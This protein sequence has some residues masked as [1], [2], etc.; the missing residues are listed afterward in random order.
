MSH[1]KSNAKLVALNK[2][3]HKSIC[4]DMQKVEAEGAD[5]HMIP[6]VLSEF[7][8]L[9]VQYPIVFSKN[10]QTGKFMCSALTGF[11]QGENL[12]WQQGSWQGVYLPLQIARQPFFLGQNEKRKQNDSPQKEQNMIMCI[13]EASPA[14][15]TGTTKTETIETLFDLDGNATPYLQKQQSVLSQLLEGEQQTTLFIEKLLSLD[16]LTAMT[17][18]ITFADKSTTK[19]N[20]LYTIDEDKL[21]QLK[22]EQL[23]ELQQQD[24]LSA[25]YAMVH[26]TGQIY[27]LIDMKNQRL[28]K[29]KEWFNT[30]ANSKAS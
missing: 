14:I 10:A 2:N 24:F 25:V 22:G 8:K 11:E 21:A 5:I 19:I 13:N 12:F 28:E 29:A 6:V 1:S 27:S 7:R 23:S 9:I 20:G 3:A 15:A 18:D 16:L 30:A 26:S 4:I 17:L